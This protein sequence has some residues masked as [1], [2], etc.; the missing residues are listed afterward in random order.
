MK[1]ILNVVSMLCLLVSIPA[2]S[3]RQVRDDNPYLG[4]WAR[5]TLNQQRRPVVLFKKDGTFAITHTQGSLIGQFT[6]G[7]WIS[8]E[9]GL[10]LRF[11]DEDGGLGSPQPILSKQVAGTLKFEGGEGYVE[12]GDYRKVPWSESDDVVVIPSR[13]LASF[14]TRKP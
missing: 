6:T 2:C 7:E 4:L 5:E 11:N 3:K 10:R 14:K 12:A 8:D 13:V 1:Q 9:K